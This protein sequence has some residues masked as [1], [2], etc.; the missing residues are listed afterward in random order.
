[1][2]AAGAAAA[3]ATGSPTSRA[4][5]RWAGWSPRA[6]GSRRRR[7]GALRSFELDPVTGIPGRERR[8]LADAQAERRDALLKTLQSG[9]L[10]LAELRRQTL[11][12]RDVLTRALEEARAESDRLRAVVPA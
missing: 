7:P 6:R 12:W 1:V 4:R 11:A 2:R 5:T 9:A 10:E 8:L 3:A